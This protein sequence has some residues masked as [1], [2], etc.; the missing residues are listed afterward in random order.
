[1][2]QA[3]CKNGGNFRFQHKVPRDLLISM[4]SAKHR[5]AQNNGGK[6]VPRRTFIEALMF[7]GFDQLASDASNDQ[8]T[9]F[10]NQL[11]HDTFRDSGVEQMDELLDPGIITKAN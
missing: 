1:M 6:D 3:L 9:F 5:L 8:I 7:V 2:T 4:N 10:V 11:I